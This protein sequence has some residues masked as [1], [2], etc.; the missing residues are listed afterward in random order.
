MLL[1]LHSAF[2][3]SVVKMLLKREVRGCALNSHGNY[4]V[5]RGKSWKN[6]GVVFLNF[7]GN[8]D[9]W[10]DFD[11]LSNIAS[12]VITLVSFDFYGLFKPPTLKKLKGHIALGLCVCA[13]LSS[14][15]IIIII[16]N[17]VLQLSYSK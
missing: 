6:H 11:L 14:P 10:I 9:L 17:I 12:V 3:L 5:G 7:C 16:I 1:L 4:M 2:T 15:I 8:P 13:S